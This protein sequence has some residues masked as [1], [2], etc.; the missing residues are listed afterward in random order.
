MS[1]KIYY[2]SNSNILKIFT[3][4][5]FENIININFSKSSQ[6]EKINNVQVLQNF[7]NSKKILIIKNSK[8]SLKRSNKSSEI[9]IDILRGIISLKKIIY[10]IIS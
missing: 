8:I 9:L 2:N 7:N 3:N 10:F 6:K 5:A 4:S 1:N